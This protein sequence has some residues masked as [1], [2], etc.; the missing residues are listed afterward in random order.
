[1]SGSKLSR[2]V[3][4]LL[5]VVVVAWWWSVYSNTDSNQSIGSHLVVVVAYGVPSWLILFGAFVG[6][7]TLVRRI[8]RGR[9]GRIDED[10]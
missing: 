7:R 2:A 9:E 4:A 6:V 3:G 5:L 10:R 1:L 8:S